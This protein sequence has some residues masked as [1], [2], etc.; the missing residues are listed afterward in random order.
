MFRGHGNSGNRYFIG[1]ETLIFAIITALFFATPRAARAARCEDSSSGGS[2][3][4]LCRAAYKQMD[5]TLQKQCNDNAAEEKRK[6]GGRHKCA[7]LSA[8][9]SWLGVNHQSSCI[10]FP[11]MNIDDKLVSNVAFCSCETSRTVEEQRWYSTNIPKERMNSVY[12][13]F[14]Y[15]NGSSG[16]ALMPATFANDHKYLKTVFECEELVKPIASDL[17]IFRQA[18]E[19]QSHNISQTKRLQEASIA[20]WL[21]KKENRDLTAEAQAALGNNSEEAAKQLELELRGFIPMAERANRDVFQALTSLNDQKNIPTLQ[22]AA[23]QGGRTPQRAFNAIASEAKRLISETT[24]LQKQLETAKNQIAVSKEDLEKALNILSR[25]PAYF[26]NKKM[27]E[28]K[29][30]DPKNSLADMT[31]DAKNKPELDRV[32]DQ[33]PNGP[34]LKLDRE[35]PTLLDSQLTLK[36]P[37]GLAEAEATA[38]SGTSPSGETVSQLAPKDSAQLTKGLEARPE[39]IENGG[40]AGA[41]SAGLPVPSGAAEGDGT[42]S[43]IAYGDPSAATPPT[44]AAEGG[45]SSFGGSPVSHPAEKG[46]AVPSSDDCATTVRTIIIAKA[47]EQGHKIGATREEFISFLSHEGADLKNQI[48]SQYGCSAATD[49]IK[50]QEGLNMLSQM[51]AAGAATGMGMSTASKVSDANIQ[52]K[53]NSA[54]IAK[55][56]MKA[57]ETQAR[58]L[59]YMQTGQS[60]LSV[61]GGTNMLLTASD[62][63]KA[64]RLGRKNIETTTGVYDKESVQTAWGEQKIA[65]EEYR[66]GGLAVSSLSGEDN[67][68]GSQAKAAAKIAA[69]SSNYNKNAKQANQL[70]LATMMMGIQQLAGAAGSWYQAEEYK[71]KAENLEDSNPAVTPPPVATGAPSGNTDVANTPGGPG[72]AGISENPVVSTSDNKQEDG[73]ANIPP[74][75]SG[76]GGN[77]GGLK[78]PAPLAS[79]SMIGPATGSGGGSGGG[80][81][82]GGGGGG[83]GAGDKPAENAAV[84][85]TGGPAKFEST[86]GGAAQAA[87]GSAGGSNR[88]VASAGEMDFNKMLEAFMPKQPGADDKPAG[89]SIAFALEQERRKNAGVDDGSILGKN[90]NLFIRVSNTT[91]SF[92]KRGNIR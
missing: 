54:A 40:R 72:D 28:P 76:G 17:H 62:Q 43:I 61:W 37:D 14:I 18:M 91:M 11:D 46:E 2:C 21:T 33:K 10:N 84:G 71:Q 68:K 8:L 50:T 23:G 42:R 22:Q 45:A 87:F 73:P 60:A 34:V 30:Q 41:S 15:N 57:M 78:D 81:L 63:E 66:A 36:K 79:N 1:L 65:G 12:C 31:A 51:A 64:A 27:T 80:G 70:G 59:A 58:N 7:D 44:T 48:E 6:T 88:R 90:A 32:A 26:A 53:G 4:T 24:V 38:P 9:P 52:N 92:Y 74:P 69:E 56:S 89:R 39:A 77:P 55:A 29:G 83:A 13:S 82:S 35:K 16:E 20:P 85:A 19:A 49:T 67:A 5:D 25:A 47:R 86:G 75:I 3:G